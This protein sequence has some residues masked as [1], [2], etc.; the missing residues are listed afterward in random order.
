MGYFLFLEIPFMRAFEIA[1]NT[2]IVCA[3]NVA[4]EIAFTVSSDLYY[5]VMIRNLS[6][7]ILGI[8]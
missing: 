7:E 2:A 6:M 8:G 5:E 3:F 1:Q 4:E